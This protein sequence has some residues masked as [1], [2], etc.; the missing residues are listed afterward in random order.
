MT[1][2]KGQEKQAPG[3]KRARTDDVNVSLFLSHFDWILGVGVSTRSLMITEEGGRCIV[4]MR[5]RSITRW[6]ETVPGTGEQAGETTYFVG[7]REREV[8]VRKKEDGP[9]C[10]C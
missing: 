7:E 6:A 2:N 1:G 4:K 10:L 3:D 5:E 8:V 9:E